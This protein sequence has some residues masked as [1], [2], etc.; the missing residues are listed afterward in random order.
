MVCAKGPI[1]DPERFV[2]VIDKGHET[3]RCLT[4][5]MFLPSSGALI[6]EGSIT[7]ATQ[8]LALSMLANIPK[9]TSSAG[10]AYIEEWLRLLRQH[11]L[12]KYRGKQR[13]S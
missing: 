8:R 11:T 6:L 1:D 5:A 9:A 10:E 4:Q 7:L 13:G 3:L 12:E 2:A